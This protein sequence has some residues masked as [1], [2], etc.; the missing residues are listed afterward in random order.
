MYP[1]H[2]T[3]RRHLHRQVVESLILLLGHVASACLASD[4]HPLQLGIT[5]ALREVKQAGVFK[6]RDW[7]S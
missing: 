7:E 2:P 3:R 6:R 4:L 1:T 5:E